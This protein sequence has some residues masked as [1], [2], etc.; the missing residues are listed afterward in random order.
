MI[1]TRMQGII[2]KGRREVRV[3]W[4]FRNCGMGGR[5][6][7]KEFP[8]SNISFQ[9]SMFIPL[10]AKD[11]EEA[12]EMTVALQTRLKEIIENSEGCAVKGIGTEGGIA[13]YIQKDADDILPVQRLWRMQKQA[14]KDCG[15]IPGK[16]VL[17]ALDPAASELE[18]AYKETT[19]AKDEI[20]MYE[21]WRDDKQLVLSREELFE[22][23]RKAIEE[24]DLPIVS[25]EDGFAEDDDDGWELLMEK[26]G[27]RIHI[28]GDDNIT[29]KD[30]S[31]EEKADRGLINTALIKLNQIGT[32]TEGTL[33]LL[34]AIGKN[35]EIIVS[36][37]SKSPLEDFEGQVALAANSLGLKAGGGSNSERL[38][39]YESVTK[40][41]REM[42]QKLTK[43][44]IEEMRPSE[45]LAVQ[46]FTENLAITEIIGREAST[47]TGIPTV[48]VEVKAG[49]G[50][51][52]DY[53]KLLTF[54]GATPLG[55]SAGSDEAIH[56][57]DSIIPANSPVAKKYPELFALQ[58]LDRTYRFK[59]G[60][61][62]KAIASKK[63]KELSEL[64]RRANRYRGKGCLNAVD[65]VMN[66]ISTAFIGTK[67]TEFGEVIELDRALMKIEEKLAIERGILSPD[68]SKDEKIKI[69]Q[70]KGNLGMNA[71]LSMSL[72]LAR[73]KGALRGQ[74]LWEVIR[75]QMAIT[76]SKTIEANG[77]I[78]LLDKL[79]ERMIS[80]R[81][82]LV[83]FKESEKERGQGEVIELSSEEEA[84]IKRGVEQV[85]DRIKNAQ[86]ESKEALWKIIKKE[87]VLGEL[88]MGLQIV[89]E[90]KPKDVKLYQLL[91]EQ[92]PVYGINK[93][94]D[95]G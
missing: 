89:N 11:Y 80:Y 76:M 32:V 30:S 46:T 25:I 27:D 14:I 61:D 28:V 64:W 24:D 84:N 48:A 74:K 82:K 91:R 3:P 59:K 16:D 5:H 41:L 53:C 72:A 10:S 15:Y 90:R 13:A 47:N 26:L 56:L 81:R 12:Q 43:E 65:N 52:G 87:L 8:E 79:K 86:K 21:A 34:T 4:E 69:M 95:K 7:E 42:H 31:I 2:L 1:H 36:H 44:K 35:L 37:R 22:I 67:I 18:N 78:E 77:G 54:E 92:L 66:I 57:I 40:V 29:T 17:M 49:I 60:I 45:K 83:Q 73:L 75:E 93:G 55:T 38:Y 39:K 50:R 33:A 58:K 6:T 68:A 94:K 71:I 88:S 85:I 19:G 62:D 9:E 70:R 23:Y 20:G 51:S 63:D